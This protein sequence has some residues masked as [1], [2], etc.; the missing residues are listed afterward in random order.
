MHHSKAEVGLKV[1]GKETSESIKERGGRDD[2]ER[3][4]GR[5]AVRRAR[6]NKREREGENDG[7]I[8]GG[9]MERWA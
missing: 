7:W 8:E 5:K 1:R 6:Q 9:E 2:R 3:R 4:R